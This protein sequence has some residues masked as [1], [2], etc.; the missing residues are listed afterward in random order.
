MSNITCLS[1]SVACCALDPAK[2][3]VGKGVE[4]PK[5]CPI[6]RRGGVDPAG[7]ASGVLH[8]VRISDAFVVITNQSKRSTM[9]SKFVLLCSAAQSKVEGMTNRSSG[10]PT[11]EDDQAKNDLEKA[12]DY[13]RKQLQDSYEIGIL[14]NQTP[15][16]HGFPMMRPRWYVPSRAK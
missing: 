10:D 4:R 11:Q 9:M 15:V 5:L 8:G 12:V 7:E 16:T 1:F 6:L 13:I 3:G 2:E 14:R